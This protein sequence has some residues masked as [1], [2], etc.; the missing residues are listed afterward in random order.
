MFVTAKRAKCIQCSVTE[1]VHSQGFCIN[2]CNGNT[3]IYGYWIF[4][5]KNLCFLYDFLQTLLGKLLEFPTVTIKIVSWKRQRS[6][7]SSPSK[8]DVKV[9]VVHPNANIYETYRLVLL[10]LGDNYIQG[11]LTNVCIIPA[12]VHCVLTMSDP[13]PNICKLEEVEPVCTDKGMTVI[14]R[15]WAECR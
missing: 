3:F 12:I 5:I 7:R 6:E 11:V 14:N 9:L 4:F 10:N 13:C 2:A 15:C 1:F 8:S